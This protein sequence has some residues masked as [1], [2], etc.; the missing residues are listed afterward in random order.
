[1]LAGRMGAKLPRSI[2][3]LLE[4]KI[5]WREA[6]RDFVTSTVKGQG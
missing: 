1:M 2:T 5:D 3:D 4:P 6:L